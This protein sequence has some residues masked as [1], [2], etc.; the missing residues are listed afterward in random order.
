[1]KNIRQRT[2]SQWRI[3]LFLIAAFLFSLLTNCKP[4]LDVLTPS[5][6][7]ADFTKSIAVGNNF[8]C[9]YQDGALYNKGQEVSVAALLAR[10]FAFV[11]GGNF[12]QPLMPDDFGIGINL[13]PW[14]EQY[15]T[16]SRLGY[17][18]DCKGVTSISP[19]YATLIPASANGYLASVSPDVNNFSVPFLKTADLFNPAS[20]DAN[21]NIYFHRFASNPGTSTV[22]SDAV[23]SNATFFSLWTGI[24]DIYDYARNGGYNKTI[25]TAAQFESQLDSLLGGLTANGAKGIIANIPGIHSFPFYTLIPYNGVDLT[26]I[27]ADSLNDIYNLAG[28]TH[29]H[30]TE[31][32]NS[33]VID[34]AAAPSGVRQILSD[35]MILLS[36]PLDSMKCYFFG[37]LFS[38]IPDRCAIDTAELAFIEQ[39]IQQYNTIIAQKAAQYDLAFADMNSFFSSVNAGIKWDGVDFNAEFI[40]GGFYSLDGQHPNQKGYSLVAN[41]FLKAIDSKYGSTLPPVNCSECDGVL[42]P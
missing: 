38:T 1:M 34:D 10:Q 3:F 6:G 23:Y 20:G 11:G 35:E 24:E 21:G 32:K 40:G 30:F 8:L 22:F 26:Q 14:E 36:V 2:D 17:R 12:L 5:A 27:K 41:E 7:S 9:G 16:R 37:I 19:L 29:I 28:L 13:K 31:G 39:S 25:P 15:I 33:F 4:D 18:T 42:F